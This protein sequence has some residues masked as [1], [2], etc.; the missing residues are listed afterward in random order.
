MLST[1]FWVRREALNFTSSSSLCIHRF[2]PIPCCSK[3]TEEALVIQCFFSSCFV[4]MT[5]QITVW[6]A[7]H[8]AYLFYFGFGF[9][10]CTDACC[11]V[12]TSIDR[13]VIATCEHHVNTW[14][15]VENVDVEHKIGMVVILQV[16][17]R[18][19]NAMWWRI[20]FGGQIEVWI[21]SM[22][23]KI[24]DI[25]FSGRNSACSCQLRL[26]RNVL[27]TF[28]GFSLQVKVVK[29]TDS[30]LQQTAARELSLTEV[31][32]NFV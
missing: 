15:A 29:Q 11:N 23:C 24:A 6:K 2:Y 17:G 27:Q 9:F 8:P 12:V 28:K 16:N 13:D 26:C 18:L 30:K 4:K 31:S 20:D 3:W 14:Y 7:R 21:L 22:Y 19:L 5:R 32:A 10:S 1:S 25:I